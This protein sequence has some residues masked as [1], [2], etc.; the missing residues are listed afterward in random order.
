MLRNVSKIEIDIKVEDKISSPYS[1]SRKIKRN[2]LKKEKC[3]K[4]NYK[5]SKL[6]VMISQNF[7]SIIFS[8]NLI[9][10]QKAFALL[11]PC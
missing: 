9:I 1:E 10:L 4:S 5:F 3:V 7:D 8:D 6:V 2:E 11:M